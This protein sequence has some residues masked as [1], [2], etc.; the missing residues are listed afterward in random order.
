MY[1]Q[2]QI[3]STT[4]AYKP[5]EGGGG[6]GGKLRILPRPLTLALSTQAQDI[7]AA[8]YAGIVCPGF[9]RSELV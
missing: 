6:S 8:A 5:Q 3:P 7:A 9:S 1:N 4:G 2:P